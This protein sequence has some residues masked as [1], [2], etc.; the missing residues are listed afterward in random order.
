MKKNTVDR[1]FVAHRRWSYTSHVRRQGSNVSV[2]FLTARVYLKSATNRPSWHFHVSNIVNTW[3]AQYR[4]ITAF[5]AWR[6][7][8]RRKT[9]RTDTISIIKIY[10]Y[11]GDTQYHKASYFNYKKNGSRITRKLSDL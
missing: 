6:S 4:V 11:A 5:V 10:N 7:H 3:L 2:V 1:A 8:E 9:P